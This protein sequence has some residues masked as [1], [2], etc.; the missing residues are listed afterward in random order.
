MT[1]ARISVCAA[2]ALSMLI[3]GAVLAQQGPRRPAVPAAP[4]GA[5]IWTIDTSHT[6][7]QFAVK[8]ML[9][10]T[11]RGTLGPVVGWVKYDGQN[12]SSLAV[13]VAIDVTG[14]NTGN[15]RRDNHL[16]SDDF[17]LVEQHPDITFVSKR[18]EGVTPQGFKLVGDLTIRGTTREVVLDVE[19]PSKP[20]Q[21][22]V[23]APPVVGATATTTIN[24][25]DFGVKYNALIEAGGAVVADEVKITIDIEA[26]KRT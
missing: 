23:S 5:D 8:H 7:A 15:G 9:V 26:R 11:V 19:G 1:K 24:R 18:V 21:R 25:K 13:N 22:A 17:L 3:S 10:S 16:R 2:A 6:S 4:Q 20:V 12:A 14:I